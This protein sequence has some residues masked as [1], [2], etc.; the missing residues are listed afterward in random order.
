[1]KSVNELVEYIENHSCDE[2]LQLGMEEK[3]KNLDQKYRQYKKN[4]INHF[5][6]K[7]DYKRIIWNLFIKRIKVKPF[8][9]VFYNEMPPA[10]YSNIEGVRPNFYDGIEDLK[11]N[12]GK[13]KAIPFCKDHKTQEVLYNIIHYRL[14]GD[15][16][17]LMMDYDYDNIIYFDDEL[18][19]NQDDEL[20]YRVCKAGYK[21]L[22]SPK[23]KSVYYSRGSLRKLW[24]QY[25]QYGFWKVRVMQKHGKTASMR[26]LVPMFFVLTNIFGAVL[27]IFFKPILALW[28]LELILYLSCDLVS[29]FKLAKKQLGL[30]KYLPLIFPILHISYGL[31]FI[32]GIIGFY[33]LRSKKMIDKNTK[34]SR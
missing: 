22:L 18:V 29:S 23:I 21:I 11:N 4:Y 9:H 25:Y 3:N 13:I 30:M 12:I 17:N 31:G 19:R 6:K 34:M 1:M 28:L 5:L 20:N 33:I 15:K 32:N 16:N 2:L 10:P 27:G 24:K 14:F 8:S 26:H 7:K